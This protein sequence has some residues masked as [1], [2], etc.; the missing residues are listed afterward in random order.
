LDERNR[1][2]NIQLDKEIFLRS[3]VQEQLRK[4]EA[5]CKQ[6]ALELEESKKEATTLRAH[7]E[8]LEEHLSLLEPMEANASAWKEELLRSQHAE[9]KLAE[10]LRIVRDESHV[11]RRE[12]ENVA[13]LKQRLKEAQCSLAARESEAHTSLG[14]QGNPASTGTGSE[15][16]AGQ[17]LMLAKR[18]R[19]MEGLLMVITNVMK[20]LMHALRDTNEDLQAHMAQQFDHAPPADMDDKYRLACQERDEA[21][22]RACAMQ[23]EL[24]SL[25]DGGAA[26][27][28]D[29]ASQFADQ[30]SQVDTV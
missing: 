9:H 17:A 12:V 14:E 22:L 3:T 11:L 5:A 30:L 27:M 19:E 7:V 13:E 16:A 24:E 29:T 6:L 1:I 23:A 21:T 20:E 2:T 18:Q 26:R 25:R 15:A 28:D 10:E 4:S 8:E